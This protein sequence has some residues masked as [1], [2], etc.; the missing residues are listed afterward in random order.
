MGFQQSFQI[1]VGDT[2]NRF[3]I[4]EATYLTSPREIIESYTPEFEELSDQVRAV[5]VAQRQ[6]NS[7]QSAL[8]DLTKRIESGETTLEA[9]ARAAGEVVETPLAPVT[10]R[11]AGEAGPC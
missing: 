6:Q 10:R 3:D 2:S 5:L 11:N 7:V 8:D 9:E 4:G 1:G